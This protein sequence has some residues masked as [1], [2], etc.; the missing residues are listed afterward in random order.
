MFKRLNAGD[1]VFTLH[2]GL[3]HKKITFLSD[4]EHLNS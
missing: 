1:L 4:S 2:H 3:H